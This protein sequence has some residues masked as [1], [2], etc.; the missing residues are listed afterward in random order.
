MDAFK[1]VV[2][3]KC[4]NVIQYL[5]PD[6]G[7]VRPITCACGMLVYI[8]NNGDVMEQIEIEFE[9]NKTKEV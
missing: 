2:H 5:D 3:N 7:Y 9:S 8:D 4:K 6:M 1:Y